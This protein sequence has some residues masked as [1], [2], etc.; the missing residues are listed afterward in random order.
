MPKNFPG[1]AQEKRLVENS[2]G[3]ANVEPNMGA[4]FKSQYFLHVMSNW[5]EFFLLRQGDICIQHY[6]IDLDKK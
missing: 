2:M 1:T 3:C 4:Q 6:R 5:V